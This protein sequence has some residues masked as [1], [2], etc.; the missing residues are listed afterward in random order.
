MPIHRIS[1]TISLEQARS[2]VDTLDFNYIIETMCAPTYPL[3]RWTVSDAT[4]CAQLYKNFLLLQKKY[5]GIP[6]VPT[7]EIDEF[8]HNHILFTKNYHLDCLNIF[9]FYLHHEPASP[10]DNPEKLVQDYANTKQLY[11]EEFKI[12]IDLPHPSS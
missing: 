1:M 10:Q 2:Y 6:L 9:G 11:F 3:P 4:Y 12:K 5:S 7:R 8:W